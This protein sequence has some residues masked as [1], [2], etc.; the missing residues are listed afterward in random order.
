MTDQKLTPFRER[1]DELLTH[2][3]CHQLILHLH[4]PENWP[5]PVPVEMFLESLEG[6]TRRGADFIIG[7]VQDPRFSDCATALEKAT[8]KIEAERG[9]EGDEDSD[10]FI[11][12]E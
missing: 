5:L 10:I 11:E 8:L 1:M 4:N 2:H 3:E 6:D 12:R 7:N 9:A